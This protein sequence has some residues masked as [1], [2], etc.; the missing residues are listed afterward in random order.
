MNQDNKGS[1]FL[2]QP[3]GRYSEERTE[4]W[5]S[6]QSQ[7]RCQSSGVTADWPGLKMELRSGT[8]LCSSRPREKRRSFPGFLMIPERD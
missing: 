4:A 3:W 2:G 5:C 6:L 7:G 8:D 1:Y